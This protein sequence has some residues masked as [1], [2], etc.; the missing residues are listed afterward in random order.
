MGRKVKCIGKCNFEDEFADK[1]YSRNEQES[2]S[3]IAA[4][5]IHVFDDVSVDEINNRANHWEND[6]E[7]NEYDYYDRR[8]R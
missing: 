6:R 1:F 2:I 4:Y 8:D 3:E 5:N 7:Y